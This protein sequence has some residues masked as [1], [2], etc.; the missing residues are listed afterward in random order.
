[1]IFT[2][3]AQIKILTANPVKTLKMISKKVFQYVEF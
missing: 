1:M 3:T 2:R